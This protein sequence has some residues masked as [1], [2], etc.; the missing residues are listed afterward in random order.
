M[1][2][3]DYRGMQDPQIARR[4]IEAGM[5]HV[6]AWSSK[7]GINDATHD[8]LLDLAYANVSA[9]LI[10]AQTGNLMD[11]V[12]GGPE[13][14]LVML[15]TAFQLGRRFPKDSPVWNVFDPDFHQPEISDNLLEPLTGPFTHVIYLGPP[16][17]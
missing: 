10:Y 1:P 8:M 9:F 15:Y 6:E 16:D 3:Q 7:D 11:V 13:M 2:R 14:N 5:K 17:E 12:T 4:M